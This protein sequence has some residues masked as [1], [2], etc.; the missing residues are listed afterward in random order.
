MNRHFFQRRHTDGQ[1]AQG[2]MLNIAINREMHIKDTTSH[3]SEWLLLK[4]TR[5]N[6]CWAECG[7]KRIL[8]LHWW[9]RKLLQPLWK[10]ILRRLKKLK[11]SYHMT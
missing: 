9:E 6:K 11:Q 1:D 4:K 2:K 10:T 5:N 7:E 3:L 8:V